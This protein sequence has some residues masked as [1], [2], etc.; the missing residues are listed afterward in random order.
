[1]KIVQ[2]EWEIV[3]GHFANSHMA[4]PPIGDPYFV[5]IVDAGFKCATPAPNKQHRVCGNLESAKKFCQEDFEKRIK[6]CLDK[7]EQVITQLK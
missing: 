4:Q 3:A 1:M 7:D 6:K 2:L 5:W